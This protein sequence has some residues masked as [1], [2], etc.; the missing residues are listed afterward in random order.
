MAV[1][2]PPA[3]VTWLK[4]GGRN[5]NQKTNARAN[6]EYVLQKKKKKPE[7]GWAWNRE[8]GGRKDKKLRTRLWLRNDWKGGKVG[9][10][11]GDGWAGGSRIEK[12]KKKE[13]LS[14]NREM[15]RKKKRRIGKSHDKKKKND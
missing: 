14:E 12:E 5:V 10:L 15:K 7:E 3:V 2:I 13:K 11:E 8:D 9:E 4:G 6:I 1:H